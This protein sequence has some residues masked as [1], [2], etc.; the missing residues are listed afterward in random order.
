VKNH[1]FTPKKILFF[2]ILGGGGAC[3]GCVPPWI[4][5]CR[6]HYLCSRSSNEWAELFSWNKKQVKAYHIIP[7]SNIKAVERGTI[8]TPN[9][10][11]HDRS[12]SW[13]NIH[14]SLKVM[15][16]D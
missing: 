16:L 10:Q 12:L 4:C 11:T 8:D 5:P 3:A 9:T 1:D 15:R 13:V 6:V 14:T 2:P 7:K